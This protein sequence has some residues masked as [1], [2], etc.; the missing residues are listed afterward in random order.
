[1]KKLATSFV[2][3][4]GLSFSSFQTFASNN[5]NASTASVA[6]NPW[7]VFKGVVQTY[8]TSNV[9]FIYKSKAEQEAFLKA[10]AEM[11]ET[12]SENQDYHSIEKIKR[13]DSAVTIFA[14]IWDIK[15]DTTLTESELE[16]LEIPEVK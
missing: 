12:L 6:E 11:K 3:I 13:I 16:A 1:M 9:D 2:I 8:K 15:N 10:A 5:S 4:L 14:F 7:E